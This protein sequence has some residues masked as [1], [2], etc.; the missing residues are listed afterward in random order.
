MKPSKKAQCLPTSLSPWWTGNTSSRTNLLNID[1]EHY[2][3]AN[4]ND[5][6]LLKS[7]ITIRQSHK[8]F[9]IFGLPAMSPMTTPNKTEHE[10]PS[11]N[12]QSQSAPLHSSKLFPNGSRERTIIHDNAEYRLRITSQGKLILTK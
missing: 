5:L 12:Q 7:F 10:Q 6:Q 11:E 8:N 1:Q 2:D 4:E 3:N 9:F